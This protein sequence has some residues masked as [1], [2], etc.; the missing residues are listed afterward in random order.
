MRI[1]YAES[2][3]FAVAW[4]AARGGR[5]GCQSCWFG[6]KCWIGRFSQLRFIVSYDIYRNLYVTE[7]PKLQL[8]EY[9]ML[10][11]YLT[12]ANFPCFLV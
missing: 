7:A 11:L 6:S 12:P 3:S 8:Q 4:G 9:T 2:T 10:T 1:G 5:K